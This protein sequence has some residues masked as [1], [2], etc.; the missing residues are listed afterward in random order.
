MRA[1]VKAAM[2][3][4]VVAASRAAARTSA[5]GVLELDAAA[6]IQKLAQ[7]P[8]VSPSAP[9]VSTNV[10]AALEQATR[11]RT[12]SVQ[13]QPIDLEKASASYTSGSATPA[14]SQRDKAAEASAKYS[15]A[16]QKYQRGN[17]AGAEA[18]CREVLTDAPDM[19][20]AH[21]LLGE[22]L[23]RNQKWEPAIAEFEKA[24]Q[25]DPENSQYHNNLGLVLSQLNKNERAEEHLVKAYKLDPLSPTVLMNCAWHYRKLKQY[26]E[27]LKYIEMVLVV[28]PKHAQA[29]N[30]RVQTLLDMASYDRAEQLIQ[31]EIAESPRSVQ[32]RMMMALL[33][34]KRGNVDGAIE[35]LRKAE[36]FTT[37][38]QLRMVLERV[39]DFDAIKDTPQFREYLASLKA[40]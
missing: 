18:D 8:L 19:H 3:D 12:A 32:P 29:R 37:R 6:V 9:I 39:H 4:A 38:D 20:P 2:E 31:E 33:M 14:P 11:P 13:T 1:D 23:S 10:E 17:L 7:R 24:I 28:S 25:G 34:V 21:N 40:Q 26:P 30:K 35:C 16:S 27:A 5:S 22:I 36:S 15:A